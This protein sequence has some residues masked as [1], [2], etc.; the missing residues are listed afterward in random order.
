MLAVI[1]L[2]MR[3]IVIWVISYWNKQMH[4]QW[5]WPPS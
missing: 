1:L 3:E 4:L 5:E 2:C